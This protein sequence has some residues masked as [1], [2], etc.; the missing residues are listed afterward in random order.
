[1]LTLPIKRTW[2]DMI[3]S[4]EKKEEYREVKPYYE[5]R[6]QNLFGVILLER[7]GEISEIMTDVP[8][9]IKREPVQEIIFRAGYSATAP[10]I[11]CKC[12]LTLGE[13]RPEW[14]AVPGKR[15]FVLGIKEVEEV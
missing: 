2:Y 14:G 11:K 1:M 13:G 12:T 8:E 9:E 7:N 15:Y 5:V 4:G 10:K 3:L 6:L